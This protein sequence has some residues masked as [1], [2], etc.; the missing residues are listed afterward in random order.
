[1]FLKFK[2]FKKLTGIYERDWCLGGYYPRG[3]N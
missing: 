1:M 3:P 2:Y